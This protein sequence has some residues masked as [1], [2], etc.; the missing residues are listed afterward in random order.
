MN[1]L[2][3]TSRALLG[4]DELNYKPESLKPR[5]AVEVRCSEA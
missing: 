5:R 2:I 4:K 1:I 3:Y